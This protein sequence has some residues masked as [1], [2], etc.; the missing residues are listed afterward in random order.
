MGRRAPAAPMRPHRFVL[1]LAPLLAAGCLAPRDPV[2]A[3][4]LDADPA[5]LPS[6]LPWHSGGTFF[7][8]PPP[9]GEL[10]TVEVPFAVNLTGSTRATVT[11]GERY[12][13]VELPRSSAYLE[14]RLVDA[15]GTEVVEARRPP[16]GEPTLTLEAKDLPLGESKLVLRIGGGS[17]EKANG[18]YVKY[19]V[20]VD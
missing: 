5:A 3:A 19:E 11:L 4:G 16:L 1:L 14:A 15:E 20:H 12:G 10:S 18:D 2:E 13:P 7:V 6:G 17:D 8:K 9:P